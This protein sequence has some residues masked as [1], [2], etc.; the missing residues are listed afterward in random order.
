MGKRTIRVL[1]MDERALLV[2]YSTGNRKET[3]RE[4]D[5]SFPY[6]T[7]EFFR[8]ELQSLRDKLEIMTDEE[9]KRELEK[10][11]PYR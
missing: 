8:W 10:G 7:D 9:F 6:V 1:D 3:I 4:I 2:M 5:G 11:D